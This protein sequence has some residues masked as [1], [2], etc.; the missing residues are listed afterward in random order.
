MEGQLSGRV[1]QCA[2]KWFGHVERMDKEQMAK[3]V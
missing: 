3:K 2:L 1:D